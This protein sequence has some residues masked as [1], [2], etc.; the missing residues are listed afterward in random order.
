M[1]I[2]KEHSDAINIRYVSATPVVRVSFVSQQRFHKNAFLPIVREGEKRMVNRRK[3]DENRAVRRAFVY[4]K[5][6]EF[7]VVKIL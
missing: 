1:N 2:S 4:S 7:V 3:R 5:S 6:M